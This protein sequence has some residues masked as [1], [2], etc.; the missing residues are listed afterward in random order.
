MFGATRQVWEK[1]F[2]HAYVLCQYLALCLARSGDS[3]HIV[4]HE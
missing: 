2:M 3:V 4:S 1:I